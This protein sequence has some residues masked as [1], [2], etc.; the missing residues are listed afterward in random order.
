MNSYVYLAGAITGESFKGATDWREYARKNFEP[1]ILGVS[2]LRR[3]ESY[4]GNETEIKLS[5]EGTPLSGSRAIM[6]GDYFDVQRCHVLLANLKDAKRIS[7]GTVMEIAWAK[8]FQKPLILVAEEG[9]LHEHPMIHEATGYR[10]SELDE[11]I[12][13][14][15]VLLSGY[16]A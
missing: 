9:N 8:A 2:P 7:V 16:S 15:N 11:G 3:T 6:T 10:V 1:G 12:H 13:I 5:Y 14:V 4:L